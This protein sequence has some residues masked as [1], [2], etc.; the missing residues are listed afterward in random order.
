MEKSENLDYNEFGFDPHMD[1]SQ[2]GQ[3]TLYYGPR[4]VCNH[5]IVSRW[6]LDKKML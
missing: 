6:Y 4:C 2:R 1:F 5:C 3:L